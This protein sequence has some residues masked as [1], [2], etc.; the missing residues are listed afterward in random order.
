MNLKKLTRQ[1]EL[2]V[3]TKK[4]T[5]KPV[6]KVSIAKGVKISKAKEKKLSKR[7]GASNIG[8]Y[9][10]VAKGEFCGT[11]PGTFPVNTAKRRK[12]ALALAHNDPHPDKVKAC[13]KRK[14]KK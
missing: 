11:T 3:P 2:R 8:E 7:P 5:A 13:V 6:K 1:E 14:G 12:S 9:K 10:K 4:T